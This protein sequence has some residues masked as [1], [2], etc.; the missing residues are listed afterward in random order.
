M[1]YNGFKQE[2]FRMDNTLER[3]YGELGRYKPVPWE[4]IP[5]LGL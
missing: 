2:E 4:Q 3:V 5:D 1:C